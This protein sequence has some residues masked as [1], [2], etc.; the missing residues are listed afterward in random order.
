MGLCKDQ[1]IK[2]NYGN[3]TLMSMKVSEWITQKSRFGHQRAVYCSGQL[4][5]AFWIR[6]DQVSLTFLQPNSSLIHHSMDHM[7]SDTF[8]AINSTYL[9]LLL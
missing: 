7:Q 5:L 9:E 2:E 1:G 4:G 3:C 6:C 8:L